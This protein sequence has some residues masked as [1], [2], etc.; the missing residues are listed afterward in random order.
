MQLPYYLDIS[1]YELQTKFFMSCKAQ[2]FLALM[3]MKSTLGKLILSLCVLK[4]LT[5]LKSGKFNGILEVSK[6]GC[7]YSIQE[8]DIK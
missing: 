8:P 6:T 1:N 2:G 3:K 5:L 7:Y 4:S